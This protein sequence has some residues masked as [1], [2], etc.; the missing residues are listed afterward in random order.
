MV[1][2]L[3]MMIVMMA[4]AIKNVT[5][6]MRNNARGDRGSYFACGALIPD[7]P[8]TELQLTRKGMVMMIDGWKWY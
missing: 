5:M 2:V 7:T 4:V 8:L 6:N 1:L 3:V